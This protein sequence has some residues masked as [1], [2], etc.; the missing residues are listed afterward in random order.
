M[1]VSYARGTPVPPVPPFGRNL[2]ARMQVAAGNA[3]IFGSGNR[4]PRVKTAPAGP[5]DP[6]AELPAAA[7]ADVSSLNG[8][9]AAARAMGAKAL[10]SSDDAAASGIA[11]AADSDAA[12]E[13][14][15]KADEAQAAEEKKTQV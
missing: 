8:L 6:A 11:A 14:E 5:A 4:A 13:K 9:D 1:D 12:A 15:K 10:H 7:A 2:A 3:M